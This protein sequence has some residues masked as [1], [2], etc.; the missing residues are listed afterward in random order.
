M[1]LLIS[2][3][4]HQRDAESE[5]PGPGPLGTLKLHWDFTQDQIG[6]F[7][8]L[9][10]EYGPVVHFWLGSFEFFMMT[11][12]ELIEEVLIR[13]SQ[14]FHKDRIS[15]ELDELLG[16][17]LLISEGKFW[18]RQR[19][20]I[21]PA[22]QRRQIAH[23]ADVMVSQTERMAT[24]WEDGERRRFDRDVM[25]ITL[26][27]VVQT[28][29]DLDIERRIESVASAIDDAMEYLDEAT[30]SLWRFVPDVIPSPKRG[31]FE[32][33]RDHLDET[34][35]ELIDARR[36]RDEPGDDL[37]YH[38]IEATDDDG[39]QMTD[40]QLRDEVITLFLAGHETTALAI[41]YA[42]YLMAEN[43]TVAEKLHEEV[44]E[45]L[46]DR[47]AG[48]EDARRLPYTEA[49]VKE[50]MRLYPPAWIIGRQAIEDVEIGPWPIAK[51]TQILMPQCIV[52]RDERWFEGPDEFRPERWLDGLEDELPRFAYF[53]FGGG[54]RI[55]IGNHF[56]KMEAILVIATLAQA[57]EFE[58]VTEQSLDTYTSITQRP[59]H[60]IDMRV[61]RR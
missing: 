30:H 1:D 16:R 49:V 48:A 61:R 37:L 3:M 23:Y 39:N 42:W 56:A 41:T 53:P 60:P 15:H 50:A 52:H 6:T 38:L 10:R 21:A 4:L 59:T 47:R 31:A 40:R 5:P 55:C 27:I 24:T 13:K 17:G 54:P 7:R 33:A 12:P 25:E 43:P 34:I 36:K 29:F 58:N 18:R 9:K 2:K 57:F 51:G 14:S 11:E 8:K 28:L 26:R 20:Q 46:G 35:F 32:E 44:D 19:K 45:V 22:L